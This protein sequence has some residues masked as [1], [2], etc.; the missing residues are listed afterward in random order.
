MVGHGQR[1]KKNDVFLWPFFWPVGRKGLTV[2][3]FNRGFSLLLSQFVA[4]RVV[5]QHI[6]YVSDAFLSN[7]DT[8]VPGKMSTLFLTTVQ[9]SLP[10][11]LGVHPEIDTKPMTAYW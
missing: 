8:R 11:E 7:W 4:L 10:L 5:I 1:D 3:S 6:C 9:W 2:S